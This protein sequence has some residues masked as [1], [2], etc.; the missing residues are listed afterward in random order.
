MYVKLMLNQTTVVTFK[1]IRNNGIGK[2]SEAV[3]VND[4]CNNDI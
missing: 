1:K 4:K 2:H 3:L